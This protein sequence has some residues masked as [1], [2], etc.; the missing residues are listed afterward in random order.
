[1]KRIQTLVLFFLFVVT[2][3]LFYLVPTIISRINELK[4][5]QNQSTLSNEEH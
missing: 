4:A 2:G 1:M 5:A 3:L